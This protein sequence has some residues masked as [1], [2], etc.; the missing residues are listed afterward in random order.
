M[1]LPACSTRSHALPPPPPL[2][3]SSTFLHQHLAVRSSPDS[4]G[5][6]GKLLYFSERHSVVAVVHIVINCISCSMMG[7]LGPDQATQ[8]RQH[9][10][11]LFPS[12]PSTCRSEGGAGLHVAACAGRCSS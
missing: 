2:I 5:R 9:I 8:C 12:I 3:L 1:P 11:S 4:P 7:C 10:V 6:P